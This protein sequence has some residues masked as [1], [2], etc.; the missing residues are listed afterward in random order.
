MITK[1][2]IFEN[3]KYITDEEKVIMNNLKNNLN[4]YL[5]DVGFIPQHSVTK[6]KGTEKFKVRCRPTNTEK[7]KKFLNIMEYIGIG[8]KYSF[9]TTIDMLKKISSIL[10]S[11]EGDRISD[12]VDNTK[13]YNL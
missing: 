8:R 10:E 1:F 9:I 5:R 11:G 6:I 12:M 7:K 4:K 13:K 2:K 3:I